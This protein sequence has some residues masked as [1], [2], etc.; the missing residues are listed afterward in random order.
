M[1]SSRDCAGSHS[2]P[3][4]ADPPREAWK[5]PWCGEAEGAGIGG[6]AKSEHEELLMSAAFFEQPT[7]HFFYLLNTKILVVS[8]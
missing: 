8:F 3:P 4:G 7:R 6:Q 1:I 5:E 2:S